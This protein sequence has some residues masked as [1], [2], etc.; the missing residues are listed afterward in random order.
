MT[1]SPVPAG[2]FEL[3]TKHVKKLLTRVPGNSSAFAMLAVLL[4]VFLT[5]SGAALGRRC[6]AHGEDFHG[7]AVIPDLELGVE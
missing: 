3:L 7:S 2:L 5:L 6:R 1:V 4:S